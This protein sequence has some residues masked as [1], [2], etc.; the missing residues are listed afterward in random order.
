MRNLLFS[1][2]FSVL[3]GP[4]AQAAVFVH[5]VPVTY[6]QIS[7]FYQELYP[8]AMAKVVGI[9]DCS[10]VGTVNDPRVEGKRYRC[11]EV[12]LGRI[13]DDRWK[14]V[15]A[16]PVPRMNGK[17]DGYE[18]GL[19]AG[20]ILVSLSRVQNPGQIAISSMDTNSL[21]NVDIGR[22]L[23]GDVFFQLNPL[24]NQLDQKICMGLPG[25]AMK[26]EPVEFD[27]YIKKEI[28]LLPDIN[29]DLDIRINVG[30]GMFD[31]GKICSSFSTQVDA[32]GL[33]KI[34]LLSLQAPTLKGVE[35]EGL[36]VR[37][38]ANLSGI[39]GVLNEI[40][41]AFGL[42]IE[43]M[44]ASEVRQKIVE[45][46]NEQID[47]TIQDVKSGK[48]FHK[49]IDV[50]ILKKETRRLSDALREK[51]NGLTHGQHYTDRIVQAACMRLADRSGL[52]PDLEKKFFRLCSHS[53]KVKIQ[54]FIDRKIDRD[55][56]CYQFQFDPRKLVDEYQQLKWWAK[57]CNIAHRV[58]V[59]VNPAIE[60]L[61]KCLLK[62]WSSYLDP[63]AQCSAEL[64]QV[65]N[66]LTSG[67]LE[68]LV[69]LAV[70]DPSKA[71]SERE[72]GSMQIIFRRNNGATLP[73]FQR[74]KNNW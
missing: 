1:T 55:Q 57:S 62:S 64:D 52:P 67:A 48:W 59:T 29:A 47:L 25:I 72:Y 35:H 65:K 20:R 27:G 74:L 39:W 11:G 23:G 19:S 41:S 7:R 49:F 26:G 36:Q 12:P 17:K 5:E 50:S 32:Q 54:Y 70:A 13:D 37:V 66:G 16:I 61:T 43:K 2:I 53:A 10:L 42:N 6:E 38:N 31:S 24:T 21:T 34:Q 56:G 18:Y 60:P 8:A 68:G 28:W 14:F 69:A 15:M 63:A 51:I 4:F 33:P 73:D 40:T 22:R 71:P 9:P 44:I 30:K 3:I 46:A 45:I 58:E